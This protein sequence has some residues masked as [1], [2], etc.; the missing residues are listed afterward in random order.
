M[1]ISK[2]F[3]AAFFFHWNL[4]LFSAGTATGLISGFGDIVIPLVAAA[5]IIYLSAT[6]SNPKFQAFVDAHEKN[7]DGDDNHIQSSNKKLNDIFNALKLEDYQQYD[8][9]K[10][11]CI[12]IRQIAD[13]IKGNTTSSSDDYGISEIQIQG[14]NRLLWI[15]LK[16]LY[17]KNCLESFFDTID[18]KDIEEDINRTKKRL[19]ELGDE[20]ENDSLNEIKKRKLLLDTLETSEYRG[21][22]YYIAVEN[23]EFICLELERLYSKISSLAEMGVNRH[24]SDF[25]TSEIDVVSNSIKQTE[26]TMSELDFITGLSN[27]N[28]E[29]PI[30]LEG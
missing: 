1:Q 26:K 30:L 2:Y 25:L 14:I 22:N 7:R 16:L 19:E 8:A 5:E 24:D 6:A 9:L 3:F 21:K 4:L 11:Q 13:G 23:Y 28:E 15:Y 17:G 20:D 27:E 12:K 18:I 29:T 10:N